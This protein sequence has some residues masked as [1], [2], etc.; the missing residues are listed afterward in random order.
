MKL[1]AK[2]LVR[3]IR[4]TVRDELETLVPRIVEKHLAETY[5]RKLV[6]EEKRPIREFM[7]AEG[8]HDDDEIPSPKENDH[9]GIYQDKENENELSEGKSSLSYLLSKDNPFSSFYEGVKA[10]EEPATP[11]E[12]QTKS[13]GPNM[14]VMKKIME[15]MER[16]GPVTV[17]KQMDKS[18]EQKMQELERRRQMLEVKVPTTRE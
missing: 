18:Y 4:E 9:K 12:R 6:Q 1:G 16:I 3:L 14:A 5:I 11:P 8:Q 7:T 15:G 17:P 2:E 10:E 13:E